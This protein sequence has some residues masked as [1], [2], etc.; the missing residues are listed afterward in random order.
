MGAKLLRFP[1]ADEEP[2]AKSV[3]KKLLREAIAAQQVGFTTHAREEME[4]DKLQTPDVLN[5]MRAGWVEEGEQQAGTWRYR[6]ATQ[7]MV[8]VVAFRG[9][10]A[11]VVTA[12]RIR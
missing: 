4:K 5:V 1:R 6:V 9:R 2:Y 12:W 7:R 10:K 8:V 3:V 11:V